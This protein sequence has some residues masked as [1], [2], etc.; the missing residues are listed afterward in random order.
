[1]SRRDKLV[2]EVDR[3][4]VRRIV[5]V[6]VAGLVAF[7]I[8]GAW[9]VTVQRGATGSVRSGVTSPSPAYA[10]RPEVG[11]VYQQP[12]AAP[13]AAAKRESA[14]ELLESTGWVDRDAGVAHVPIDQ[15][16]GLV[17]TGGHL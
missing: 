1:M 15:A 14:R 10:G 4:P 7:A 13:I 16:M 12:F 8:G 17:V 11:M 3:V 2:Q 9:S 6:G 5:G